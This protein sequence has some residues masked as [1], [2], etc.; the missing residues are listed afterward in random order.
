LGAAL[1]SARFPI[2]TPPATLPCPEP[3]WRL[4]DGGYFENSGL[5][6]AL[7]LVD[8]MAM[9]AERHSKQDRKAIAAL[10]VDSP[11]PVRVVLIRI[12]N[13]EA[14]TPASTSDDD[15]P[16]WF[17]ELLSPLRAFGGTRTARADLAREAVDRAGERAVY[18]RGCFGG[19]GG[20]VQFEQVRLRL[21]PCQTTIPLGWSLS[22]RAK[23]EIRRQLGIEAERP[24]SDCVVNVAKDNQKAFSRIM[25]LA[26]TSR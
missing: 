10:S 11:S 3:P 25:Q 7:E 19:D 21:A 1:T 2:I 6:T 8:A 20:C 12:E 18:G 23:A 22:D 5:T 9:G 26:T 17:A 14:T 16:A 4:V 15:P 24:P 13:S